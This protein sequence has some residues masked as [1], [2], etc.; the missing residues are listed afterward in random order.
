MS[1]AE[2]EAE[3]R[4]EDTVRIKS[5]HLKRIVA[6]S[7]S[8]QRYIKSMP[9]NKS[10]S[11]V[12][13]QKRLRNDFYKDT[14]SVNPETNTAKR[15]KYLLP[16]ANEESPRAKA[17]G[18]TFEVAEEVELE[19]QRLG[20][21][22]GK[23]KQHRRTISGSDD[24][25]NRSR[26]KQP[27]YR[28]RQIASIE[29]ESETEMPKLVQGSRHTQRFQEE[30]VSEEAHVSDRNRTSSGSTRELSRNRDEEYGD[31]PRQTRLSQKA[32]K[33]VPVYME[34][35]EEVRLPHMTR[36]TKRATMAF[37]DDDRYTRRESRSPAKT[38]RGAVKEAMRVDSESD[39]EM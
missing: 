6:L 31:L 12:A 33:K 4:G 25:L 8:F 27:A 16:I 5:K 23:L 34:G 19:E 20:S 32:T 26:S 17:K 22:D 39:D 35:E 10:D 28:S 9:G 37:E 36:P 38:K 2:F 7:A 30:E 1:L 21:R 11:Y 14:P 29:E 24:D 3:D 15:S 18:R 13:K